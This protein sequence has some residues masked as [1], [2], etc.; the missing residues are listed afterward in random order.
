MLWDVVLV[1]EEVLGN[2]YVVLVIVR[3]SS[4][5]E[6]VLGIRSVDPLKGSICDCR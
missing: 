4:A 5:T 3:G 1:S 2:V 6:Q